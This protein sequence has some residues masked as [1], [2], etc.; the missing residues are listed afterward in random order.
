MRCSRPSPEQRPSNALTTFPILGWFGIPSGRDLLAGSATE[1][2]LCPMSD[3]IDRL[4]TALAD[5][6][7]IEQ[8]IGAGGMATVYLAED[9]RHHRKVAVK[10]LRSELAATLGPDRFLREIE[11]AAQLQHPHVLPLYDS[12]EADGFLFYVMPFV[13][14]ESL[15]QKIDREGELPVAEAARILRDVVDAIAYAHEQGVVHR[16]IK[17][18]NVLVS[19]RHAM[20][21]DFGV[22]KAVSEATGRQQ[23]TTAGVALGTPSYMA[24]EQAVAD[25]QIDHRA[26]IYAVGAMAYELLTGTPP[27]V[28]Q[29]QQ[30][31][32]AAHVTESPR[33]I[34]DHRS[35]VPPGLAD[36]VMRCLEKKPADR[37]QSAEALLP[38]FEGLATPSGGMTPTETRPVEA[39]TAPSRLKRAVIVGVI[40]AVTVVGMGFAAMAV[41][42][43]GGSS[44]LIRDRVLVGIF[45]NETAD[46][47]HD[48]IGKI[49]ADWLSRGLH[50]TGFVD[51]VDERSLESG[52][53]EGPA[54]AARLR[55]LAQGAKASLIV[56]GSYYLVGDNLELQGQVLDARDGSVVRAIGPLTAPVTEP[57]PAIGELRDRMMVAFANIL[58]PRF[59]AIAPSTNPPSYQ[60][61][62]EFVAGDEAFYEGRHVDAAERL[63]TAYRLDTTFVVAAVRAAVVYSNLGNCVTVDSIGEALDLRRQSIAPY[64][65]YY[66]DRIVARCHG[67]YQEHLRAA[68]EMM[69]AA[70]KSA[71]AQYIA[72]R[73]ALWVNRVEYGLSILEPID[74]TAAE[75]R[76]SYHQVIRDIGTGLHV[77]EAYDRELALLDEWIDWTEVY[78]GHIASVRALAGAGRF[79][80]VVTATRQAATLSGSGGPYWPSDIN[81]F[82]AQEVRAHG[83][84]TDARALDNVCLQSL[85]QWGVVNADTVGWQWRTADAL[86]RLGRLDDAIPIYRD[87]LVQDVASPDAGE[88]DWST[89]VFSIG[90][91]GR[92]GVI[93]AKTEDEA[94]A[95]QWATRL[96]ERAVQYGPKGEPTLWRAKIAV[97]LGDRDAALALLRQA[98]N[99]GINFWDPNHGNPFHADIDFEPLVGYAPYEEIIAPRQ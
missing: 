21:T 76:N 81:C 96:A 91:A 59:G 35:A 79:D 53:T 95:R 51:V 45:N 42:R 39:V 65:R 50:G 26:D 37:Y 32:L 9:L 52:G 13:E 72:G 63:M 86:Y 36:V 78:Y 93:A 16:D 10:V 19:G 98:I 54:G 7:S 64:D 74:A 6:Y 61:Y 90:A 87:V 48:P 69:R 43:S 38:A 40:A 31:V 58:D 66:L 57:Q 55:A 14:G 20:V 99:E 33:P 67:D 4:R 68:E 56:T 75:L 30:A 1:P 15:R 27:F 60:A 83:G 84:V 94:A 77:I 25:P 34:T 41:T 12:G 3:L 28:G 71:F 8:E 29:S 44:D 5:R 70:P 97:A 82:A 62:Q 18:D 73:S 80:D 49:V 88:T 92:L 89:V 46:P 85:E 22:A 17:P 2:Y 23:L 47:A 11:I 24:P